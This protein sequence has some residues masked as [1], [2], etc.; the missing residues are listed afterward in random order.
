MNCRH[1]KTD[2]RHQVLDLGFSPPSN[3][4]LTQDQLNQPEITF[5][6]R[7]Y[8][9]DNC[10]L[11]QTADFVDESMMFPETYVY[12]SSTSQ[13]WM[14]HAKNYVEM[15]V[16]RLSLTTD[17]SVIEIASNDGYLLRNFNDLGIPNFGIEPTRS[18]AEAAERIG[19]N[20]VQR[21]FDS[22]LVNELLDK[23]V[24]ADLVI[25]NNVY[26]HVPDINDFTLAISKILKPNGVVTLEFPHAE[27]LI[28]KNQFDTVYHEHFS[29]LSLIA[30]DKIFRSNNLKIFD[31][32]EIGTHGGSLRVFGCLETADI[33]T[34]VEVQKLIERET[35]NGLS[36]LSAY[37]GMQSR[38]EAT[39]NELLRFLLAQKALGKRVIG[40][41]AA[42]KGN[43]LLNFAGVR[44]DLITFVVDGAESKQNKFLPGSH[45]PVRSPDNFDMNNGDNVIIFPW[46]ISSEISDLLREK[47]D[48]D[49]SL[50]ILIPGLLAV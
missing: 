50:W 32:E 6:L 31:V 37:E 47:T 20:T 3:S 5:P 34:T 43:T 35:L 4:F 40:Y 44:S 8:V 41:G 17:S 22:V 28:L 7:I 13:S 1:C 36:T 29:Y 24:Q 46:N 30:V 33:G 10:W 39:K 23:G 21:F 42:A 18:T 49:I 2:L 12:F 45:I 11:I 9:C 38:A 25:G 48:R 16:A 19:V 15:I 27:N 14:E 26:A